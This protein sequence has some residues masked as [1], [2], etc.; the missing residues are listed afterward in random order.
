MCVVP[1]VPSRHATLVPGETIKLWS[2]SGVNTQR[3]YFPIIMFICELL[4][5]SHGSP[6]GI[7]IAVL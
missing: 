6:I 4:A 1:R 5:A 7:A 3:T 2:G